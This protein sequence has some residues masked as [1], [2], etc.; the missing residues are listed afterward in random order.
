M[1]PRR[2][3]YSHKF[4]DSA[5][6]VWGCLDAAR[7]S[8]E[9]LSL[10]DIAQRCTY[11]V[12]TV[13]KAL[14]FLKDEG[15]V[16]AWNGWGQIDLRE[17][18]EG[19][20]LPALHRPTV[21]QNLDDSSAPPRF[22]YALF[23]A[24]YRA[25]CDHYHADPDVGINSYQLVD[26]RA[27]QRRERA[28]LPD[29]NWWKHPDLWLTPIYFHSSVEHAAIWGLFQDAYVYVVDRRIDHDIP[30]RELL[31]RR[32]DQLNWVDLGDGSLRGIV[33]EKSAD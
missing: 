33:V 6:A 9:R 19:E 14:D 13:I 25:I 2:A 20:W 16:D 5:R 10:R 28:V 21:V 15:V 8:G 17:S 23:R 7:L 3:R 29:L 4:P 24:R 30:L 31:A 18:L 26:R 1:N 12:T 22:D 32:G 11:S 27:R